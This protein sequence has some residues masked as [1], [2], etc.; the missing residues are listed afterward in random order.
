[1][2]QHRAGVKRWL[3]RHV[4]GVAFVV[5]AIAL[6][7]GIPAV[8]TKP[9]RALNPV[10]VTVTILRFKALQDPEGPFEDDGGEYYGSGSIDGQQFDTRN[11]GYGEAGNANDISP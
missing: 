2:R 10:Q 3:G 4:I 6:A 5:A 8:T 11:L 7:V 1:M 9:A